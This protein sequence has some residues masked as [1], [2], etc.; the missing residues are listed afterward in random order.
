MKRAGLSFLY[1]IAGLVTTWLACWTGSRI[2]WRIHIGSRLQFIKSN[3]R[4]VDLCPQPWPITVL[5]ISFSFGPSLVFAFAGWR[6]S[7]HRATPQKVVSSLV[8][9]AIPTMLI[10]IAAYVIR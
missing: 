4:E 6:I 3:C 10:H 7:R 8:T 9:L 1:W 2:D 5:L